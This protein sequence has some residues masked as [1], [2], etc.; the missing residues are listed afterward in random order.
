M[1]LTP[2]T[3]ADSVRTRDARLIATS[4][5]GYA[6]Y[7]HEPTG[8]VFGSP[9]PT[10]EELTAYYDG[11]SYQKPDPQAF[12]TLRSA[13]ADATTSI[14]Q[15]L[16]SRYGARP[17]SLLDFGGGIGLYAAGFA[18]HF[19]EVTL[20]DIDPQ[21]CAYASDIARDRFAIACGDPERSLPD[22]PA[23]DV[24]FSSHVIEHFVDLNRFFDILVR[25]T[26]PG[27]LVVIATPNRSTWE[28]LARPQLLTY[29]VRRVTGNNPFRIPRMLW[30]L[31]TDSWLCC[32]PPRHI[33]A[34]DAKSLAHVARS[35]GLIVEDVFSEYAFTSSYARVVDQ[36][37]AKNGGALKRLSWTLLNSYAKPALKALEAADPLRA[38]GGNLVLIARK[39]RDGES[40]G[41]FSP[42][43][44]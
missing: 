29:Y 18:E 41:D 30:R 34:F 44:T 5:N 19:D 2:E 3:L 14:S 42:R 35:A 39:P 10:D 26:K 24:V 9:F 37:G 33:Y 4:R 15:D 32:D 22:T 21:A 23:F 7:H 36:L 20:F 6:Y 25:R 38:K 27:G 31:A 1:V 8:L 28:Y 43:E 40:R 11:F 16:V 17:G 13:I 12:E